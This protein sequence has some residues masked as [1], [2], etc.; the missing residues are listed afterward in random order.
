MQAEYIPPG[1]APNSPLRARDLAPAV[2]TFFYDN[3]IVRDFGI[4][5]VFW[6]IAGMLVG[7][8][9]AFQLAQPDV[10]L[11]TSFTTFGRIRPLHTN[12]VIFAFVGNGIFMGVYYSLQRLCKAAMYS[13]VLSKVHFWGW[14]LIILSALISLPMGLTTSKEYAELE[15]PIDIAITVVWVVFGWNMFGTIARRRERHLY[16]GIWFYI[17]TLI[18]VAVLHL[19]NSAEV[20]VSWMKSYSAYAGVQDALVQWWYGHNAVAFFLTTPYLG[21]MYYFLPK[22]AGRPVYSY[23]LSI[24]HFWSLI[25]I[26]I[27]AGPHHLLYTALPD[28]AQSLGVAFSVMLIA[29]SWGGMINGLLTLRGAWDKVRT[30]PVLK[31][32][33]VAVTAYGMATFEGPMLALKNVNAIAHFTDW[34]VA[35]VHVGALGWNGFLTFAML[36]WLWPR[37]Y[38]TELY[39]K[40]LANTHFWLGTVGILIYVL[41]LYWAGFTQGLMWKQFNAEG[42]LQYPNFLETVLQIVP[43]YYL[44]G[45]GGTLY[46]SGVFLMMYNL[47]KTAQAGTL[48]AEERATAPALLPAAE[49]PHADGGHWHRWIER[50]PFQLVLWATVAIAIGGLIEMIPTFLVKSNVPTIASVKPYTPLELQGRDLYIREGC[51]NCHTQMVRPFRS[52]TERYGEYSKAG[53]FVYDRPFLWGSKRTGPDL[54]RV[55]GKYPHSWHYNHLLDPTT[56]SPGS[57]MPPYPWLYDS[58]L[59]NSTLPAKIRVLQKLGT[60]YPRGYDQ[61]AVAEAQ[62]QADGI[63]RDLQKE[64]IEVKSD[65]EIVALIAY[66]QRLGTDIKVKP[67]QAA[68]A[69]Q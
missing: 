23:R 57:I 55:G 34:I 61:Q 19:V 64:E 47:I 33:V 14:Q 67:E 29:P 20:P 63:A 24:I 48:L 41:P 49:D 18:T 65:K 12:A 38:R 43:M 26:Y 51:S 27:W 66:L 6:G 13:K 31:F 42:M 59:D 46:L 53:E 50:R 36:Y 7:I 40:K 3:K 56:M 39:S 17:A 69:A 32:M 4:A 37:L 54:H 58:K 62:R 22:A 45:I 44:R 11:H 52:E 9:A 10:N 68:A 30:E 1:A 8:L 25:F 16:V 28:W 5:T 2:D 60:P 21:L 35:H 15:W